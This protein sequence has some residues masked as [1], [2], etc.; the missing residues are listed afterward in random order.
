MSCTV[1]IALVL[2]VTWSSLTYFNDMSSYSYGIL[3]T[4]TTRG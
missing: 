4:F 2:R 1:T 3:I